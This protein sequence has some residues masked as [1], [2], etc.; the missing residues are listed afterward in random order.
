MYTILRT[1]TITIYINIKCMFRGNPLT[2]KFYDLIADLRAIV[3]QPPYYYLSVFCA[4]FSLSMLF[5]DCRNLR[6][7]RNF[8]C[9][10]PTDDCM[11]NT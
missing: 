10:L 8:S 3:T 4:F 7:A 5:V 1:Y 11:S 9:S 2:C 6:L